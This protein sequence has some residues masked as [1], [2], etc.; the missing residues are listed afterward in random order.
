MLQIARL[1]Q[2]LN[3]EENIDAFTLGDSTSTFA[4]DS[5]IIRT[6]ENFGYSSGGI[7]VILSGDNSIE[8]GPH[9]RISAVD[10]LKNG[11]YCIMSGGMYIPGEDE[12]VLHCWLLHGVMSIG[13]TKNYF[14]CNFGWGGYGDGYYF[15]KVFD[16]ADGPDY[17]EDMG[18][19]VNSHMEDA[20]NTTFFYILGVRE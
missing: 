15:S 8:L 12:S 2:Q 3:M 5:N 9:M 19:K 6:L 10:E 18:T 16:T 1:M 4:N 17:E 20:E 14:L 7:R 11:Y 13:G